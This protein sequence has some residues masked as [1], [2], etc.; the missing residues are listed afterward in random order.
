MARTTRVA[1]AAI[2]ALALVAPVAASAA[3]SPASDPGLPNLDRRADSAAPVPARAKAA[4]DELERDLGRLGEVRT[5]RSSGAVAYV[6]SPYEL[7]TGPSRDDPRDIA[8]A[9]VRENF[10]AFG[11]T[12]DDIANLRLVARS[13]SPDGITHLRF[14][15]VL[16]EIQSFD[17]GLDAHVARD[18][19]LITISGSPLPNARL[20]TTRPAVGASAALGAARVAAHGSILPP[21]V[22]RTQPGRSRATTFATGERAVLRWS[23]GAD[24]PRL[25]WEVIADGAGEH[26]YSV[27]VDADDGDLLR[28]QD[29]TQHAG[30]ARYFRR[31]PDSTPAQTQITMPPA[32]FDDDAGGTRLWGQYARTYTDPSDQ[33]PSPGGEAGGTRM[34]IPASAGAP[35]AP[36]WLYTQSHDFPGATPCPVSL[37]TWNS[38]APASALTNAL[39]AATNLHVLNSRFHDHL[40]A[41]PIGFDAASGNFQRVNPAGQ[42]A[43]NDYVR[44]EVNDGEGVNNANMSTPPDGFAP[45]MQM[46]LW[47]SRDVNG[48]DDADIVYHEYGHGLSNR[49]VVNASGNSTLSALQ[50]RQMGEAWSDFYALD[51]LAAEGDVEDTAAPGEVVLA[52]YVR[53]NGLRAKPIDCPVDAAGATAVCNLNHAPPTVLGGYTYGDLASTN[54]STPHNGGEVWSQT[55]WDL[56]GAVGRTAALALITGGMRLSPDDP[57]MLDMRDAILQQALATASAPGAPEDHYAAVWSVFSARGLGPHATTRSPSS[58]T[59][60]EDFSA[61]TGLRAD[62]PTLRDPYPAG[63]NDGVIEIGETF[64]V[65]QPVTSLAASGVTVTGALTAPGPEFEILDGTA[66]WPLLARGTPAVNSDP[67]VARL[68]GGGCTTQRNLTVE[69]AS[70]AGNRTAT[71]VVDPRPGSGT[72]IDLADNGQVTATFNAS[73]AGTVSDVDVRIDDLR[74]TFLGDLIIQLEH[75]GVTRTLF[76]PAAGWGAADILDA[77]F[78]DEASSPIVEAGPG[79]VTGRIRPTVAGALAAFDGLPAAG[80]WTL[81]ITDNAPFYD[82]TL[83]RWGLDSPQVGC[84][85]VEIPEAQTAGAAAGATSATLN[86]SV[87]P[88]GRATSLRFAYGTSTAYGATTPVRFAGSGDTAIPAADD[89]TGLAPETTYHFRVEAIRENGVVAVAGQDATFTTRPAPPPPPPPAPPPPPVTPPP[90]PEPAPPPPPDPVD[91]TRPSILG[92]LTATPGPRAGGRRRVTFGFGLSEAATVRVVLTRAS[93]GGRANGRCV[94]P[95]RGRPRCTRQLAAGS[96]SRALTP[97]GGRRLVFAF[98]KRLGKGSYSARLTATAA[99]GNRSTARIVRFRVR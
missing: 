50:A 65:S 29:L 90:P 68:A 86:G 75:N 3:V 45:R 89:V 22:T 48:S 2:C 26:G 47:T 21:R 82:G 31:D 25:A 39:Q 84:T 28:R 30:E 37:C 91:A 17:S 40:L 80:A 57:S 16:D 24:G 14:N 83:R 23:A 67:L 64:T 1:A 79:P 33:D 63:D 77:V 8:L 34:Q 11:L 94:A 98:P 44:S 61:A 56:R 71:A 27:L 81:R 62:A 7:L 6:G 73:G 93:T 36:D 9:Y 13:V 5:E 85:R 70:S 76:D 72:H 58:T 78:D 53:N 60:V 15:Q 59:P 38:A 12:A 69:I 46:F 43:G 88:N 54:N 96:A 35:A 51:L 66:A 92:A 32:W 99:A 20:A 87:T 4:R 52:E 95:R 55:L 97:S 42:G 18:G 10:D 74:H 19:R 41:P 49:L